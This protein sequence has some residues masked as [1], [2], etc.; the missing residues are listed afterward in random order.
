MNLQDIL[1]YRTTCIHCQRPLVM[2]VDEYPKLSVEE[3]REGLK[4][5]SGHPQGVM[6]NFSFDGQYKRNKRNYKIYEKPLKIIKKCNVHPL[7]GGFSIPVILKS[8]T[9]GMT[10]QTYQG[11]T[12]DSLKNLTCQYE[13]HIFG[14]DEGYETCLRSE[15][16]YWRNEEEFWHINSYFKANKSQ[17]YHGY[18]LEKLENMLR[19]GLPA[20]NL[21]NVKT[22]DDFIK[23]M[24]L[25][26]LFS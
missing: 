12:L 19:L 6:L 9:V 20:A 26:T 3:T 23:K 15:F 8:R 25:Y 13:F 18:Y 11:S 16:L 14:D 21:K 24:R 2:K 17:L 5:K 7:I 4:I 22:A 1:H 10:V